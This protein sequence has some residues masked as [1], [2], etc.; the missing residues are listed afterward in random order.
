MYRKNKY[1]SSQSQTS[2]IILALGPN[3]W[4]MFP[5]KSDDGLFGSLTVQCRPTSDIH[6]NKNSWLGL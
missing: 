2:H 6:H 1:I 4:A 3:L 5:S